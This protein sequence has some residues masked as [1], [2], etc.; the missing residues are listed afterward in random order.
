MPAASARIG[1][2]AWAR[3]TVTAICR[4]RRG[5]LAVP[6]GS[7]SAASDTPSPTS[8]S[9]ANWPAGAGPWP[10]WTTD[11]TDCFAAHSG[12]GDS[13]WSDPRSNYAQTA[14]SRRS[15]LHTRSRASRTTVLRLPTRA[16]Q[17]DRASP[18]TRSPAPGREARGARPELSGWAPRHALDRSSLHISWYLR[19]PGRSC[20]PRR[21]RP[22]GS[23]RSS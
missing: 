1:L 14:R 7:S 9:P 11:P 12:L 5:R 10:R 21:G 15:I 13:A 16:Y 2:S 20:V 17:S 8:P 23:G 22:R 6:G 3:T 18:T 4:T 19:V